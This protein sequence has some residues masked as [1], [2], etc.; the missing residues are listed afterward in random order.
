MLGFKRGGADVPTRNNQIG[1][2]LRRADQ[3][4]LGSA[5]L[6]AGTFC[7]YE[8]VHPAAQRQV[9]RLPAWSKQRHLECME[10]LKLRFEARGLPVRAS[11]AQLSQQPDKLPLRSVAGGTA[12][13]GPDSWSR[14]L[15]RPAADATGA[16]QARLTARLDAAAAPAAVTPPS[17]S[18]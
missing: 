16:P 1:R 12:A 15:Q 9:D 13:A 6:T 11:F 2:T 4:G 3:F 14:P 18:L 8:Q 17:V 7:L 5:D 10:A